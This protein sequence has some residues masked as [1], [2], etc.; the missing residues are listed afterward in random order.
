MHPAPPPAPRDRIELV[1]HLARPAAEVWAAATDFS[2]ITAELRPW[3]RMTAPADQ[4][5]LPEQVQPGRRL[6]RSWLLLGGVVP[7][8]YDDLA[9]T[10]LEPGR[11]FLEQSRMLS[12]SLWQHE[13]IVEPTGAT[14]CRLVDRVAFIPRTPLHG[15]VLRWFV[16]RLFAHRHRQLRR[17]HGPA[18]GDAGTTDA[19]EG[20]P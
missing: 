7:I 14:T 10:E 4:R 3:L 16:P 9:L 1:S 13:R 17:L 12:A 20:R 18:A 8:D 11:R 15:L 19:A 5:R 6:F 2:G